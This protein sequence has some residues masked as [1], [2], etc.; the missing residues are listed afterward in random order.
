ME[1]GTEVHALRHMMECFLEERRA[2][3]LKTA[4]SDAAREAVRER[5]QRETWLADA[6]RRA[7]QISL[8]THALKYG[9][10]DAKGS[11]LYADDAALPEGYIGTASCATIHEDVVG[12]AAALDVFKFLKLEHDGK[13]LL[14][15]VMENDETLQ[16]AFSDDAER[17]AEWM[18]SFC[19]MRN[20]SG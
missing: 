11:N 6:A 3:K 7:S 15:R 16:A 12:N 8:A 2:D 9:H 10:P 14:Q 20:K 19:R 5:F 18:A 1:Q 13:S 17:A 4:K